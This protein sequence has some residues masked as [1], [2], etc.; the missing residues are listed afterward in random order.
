MPE[1]AGQVLGIAAAGVGVY[2]AIRAD[3]AYIR[4]KVE[5]AHDAAMTAHARID[6]FFDRRGKA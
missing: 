6:S 1:W 3:L 5:S 4:A 2:A